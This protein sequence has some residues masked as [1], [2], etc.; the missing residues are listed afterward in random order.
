MI[1]NS[2]QVIGG[3]DQSHIS[4]GVFNGFLGHNIEKIPLPFDDTVRMFYN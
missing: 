2:A 1:E 3:K 4:R